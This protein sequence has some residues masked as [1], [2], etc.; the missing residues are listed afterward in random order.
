ML[1]DVDIYRRN[2]K[3]FTELKKRAVPTE[4]HPI[5]AISVT[6]SFF[7]EHDE[8]LSIEL[9]T[10]LFQILVTAGL[11][12]RGTGEV[13]VDPRGEEWAKAVSFSFPGIPVTRE[14]SPVYELLNMAYGMHGIS[15]QHVDRVLDFFDKQG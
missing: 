1:R 11:I 13:V 3:S 14:A 2:K 6:S 8:R 7:H 4:L 15:D 9:S 5:D 10:K 12:D